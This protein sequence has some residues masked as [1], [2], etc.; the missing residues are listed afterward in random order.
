MLPQDTN[1]VNTDVEELMALE[2]IAKGLRL[3]SKGWCF[4]DFQFS[5]KQ[6]TQTFRNNRRGLPYLLFCVKMLKG[7]EDLQVK[8][9]NLREIPHIQRL[10]E[11][12][13]FASGS[14]QGEKIH[15]MDFIYKLGKH[16]ENNLLTIYDVFEH[17]EDYPNF[18]YKSHQISDFMASNA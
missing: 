17:P 1:S 6:V 12:G 14:N 9:K 13:F 18:D 8:L 3:I 10:I 15:I 16:I 11:N 7:S 5:I 4:K 2:P